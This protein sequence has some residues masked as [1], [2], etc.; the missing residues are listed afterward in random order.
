L[1]DKSLKS[2]SSFSCPTFPLRGCGTRRDG[3][4]RSRNNDFQKSLGIATNVLKTR[5]DGFVDAG[6]MVRHRYSQKSEL[7]EYVLTDKGRA[8]ASIIV[9]LTEWGDRWS[10]PDGPPVL[11]SHAVCGGEISQQTICATCGQVRDPAEVRARP[12]PG[13]PP[14]VA[15]RMR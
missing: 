1:L 7:N 14:E 11:Y 13:M 2:S 6:I 12:G 8:L 4:T 9:A 15:A 10:A 3:A 5:L